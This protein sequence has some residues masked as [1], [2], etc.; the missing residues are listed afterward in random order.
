MAA[1]HVADVAALYKQAHPTADPA[2]LNEFLD[3]ES[4]KDVLKRVSKSSPNRL[5]FT[6]GL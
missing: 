3:G 2:E 1:P 6:A 4:T 5:L